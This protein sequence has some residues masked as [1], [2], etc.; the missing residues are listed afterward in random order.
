MPG[1][2][3]SAVSLRRTINHFVKFAL[4]PNTHSSY[5]SGVRAFLTFAT[6]FS[7]QNMATNVPTCNEHILLYFVAHCQQNLQLAY[8][9]IKMYLAG[10]RYHY[11]SEGFEN[12]CVDQ[13]GNMY[14]KLSLM[15]K[16][17]KKS[18]SSNSTQRGPIT[19][20]ILMSMCHQ[21]RS[22]FLSFYEDKLMLAA[23]LTAFFGFLRCGE[24]TTRSA[25]FDPSCNLC[26]NDLIFK[27]KVALITIKVSKS[28]PFRKGCIIQLFKNNTVV[29]PYQGLV[30]YLSLRKQF[31]NEPLSPLF[32]LPSF[33]PLSRPIFTKWLHLLCPMPS[34]TGHSFRIGAATAAAS[35]KLPDYLIQMLGRWSS[36]CYLRYIRTPHS[37]LYEA[38]RDMAHVVQ[39]HS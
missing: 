12:P 31:S 29:C 30:D 37:A 4:S 26:L 34:I 21:L 13:T 27:D 3:T 14:P 17:I 15:L 20:S 8:S 35:A 16:G 7:I 24:F 6:M 1:A 32:M 25:V 2:I 18:Q 23:C 39:Q 19:S 38:Q 33:M 11:I 22:G 9:T 10:I 36:D 5:A 28:D